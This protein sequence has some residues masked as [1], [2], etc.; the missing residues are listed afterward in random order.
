[1]KINENVPLNER[2]QIVSYVTGESYSQIKHKLRLGE[3]KLSEEQQNEYVQLLF[4]R[5][6]G[7]PLQYILGYTDFYGRDFYCSKNVLIPRFDTE[8]LVESVLPFVEEGSEVLDMCCGSGCIG[9]TLA[10]EKKIKLT[11]ADKSPFALTLTKKNA[12]KFGLKDNVR[13]I[14]HDVF[15]DTL[16][17][18]FSLI[19]SNP[20]Y[21][22]TDDIKGLS[23]EVKREPVAALD[24][25]IDGL[26]FYRKMICSYKS[27]I[28][29]GGLFAFECGMGQAEA[30]AEM[31]SENGYRNI[32]KFKDY[33]NIDRVVSAGIY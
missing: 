21:I 6:E 12:G 31:F 11:L 19:V 25:G 13:V 16:E 14:R 5:M 10:L 24:G 22:K 15:C 28:A 32:K 30:V 9:L 17:G 18:K 8:C 33:N 1:M 2:C 20:P 7:E 29:P 27:N 3:I 26:D 23:D 4:R